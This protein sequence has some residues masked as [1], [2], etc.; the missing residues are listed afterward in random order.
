M[1]LS[2]QPFRIFLL[3]FLHASQVFLPSFGRGTRTIFYFFFC[4][5]LM[6]VFFFPPFSTPPS[7]LTDYFPLTCF[8]FSRLIPNSL[9]SRIR[10]FFHVFLEILAP[11]SRQSLSPSFFFFRRFFWP[12]I[13]S[14]FLVLISPTPFLVLTFPTFFS[15]VPP[16]SL[17]PYILTFMPIPLILLLPPFGSQKV[18]IRLLSPF[19]SFATL[20]YTFFLV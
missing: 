4:A 8:S 17:R 10:F 9:Y 20:P 6:A 14:P 1:R 15:N 5:R 19:V 11:F 2:P 16:P 18:E 13:C 3:L 7:P 12:V